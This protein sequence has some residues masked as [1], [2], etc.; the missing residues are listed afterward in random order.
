M[1]RR[2]SFYVASGAA[3]GLALL[4]APGPA[5]AQESPTLKHIKESGV[6]TF[7][8][9]DSAVPLSFLGRDGKPQGYSIDLCDKVV[10]R[11]KTELK[12]TQIE[13]K[14]VSV[15]PQTRIPMLA[16]GSIDIECGA[17]TDTLTREQQ[18]DFSDLVFV[19]ATRMLVAKSS[20]IHNLED[21]N[22][23]TV[24]LALGSTNEPAVLKLIADAKLDTK[25]LHVK[26][27]P[28]GL[29]AVQ[30]DRAD[31]YATDEIALFGQLSTAKDKDKYEVVG[32][33]LTYEPLGLMMRRNDSEF[34]RVVN[35]TLA[36]LFRTGEINAIYDKWF[37]PIGMPQGALFKAAVRLQS[38]PE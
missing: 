1:H 32:R 28:E 20:G 9:R 26:D 38:T 29:A 34:R 5:Q 7:G 27:H 18:V 33:E 4:V 36:G 3:C 19:G 13:V 25:I 12:L 2:R 37:G 15:N 22:G 10:E 6:I 21:L 31:A 30:T 14:Y 16:A 17:T 11:V 24:A 8:V 35:A 23:K